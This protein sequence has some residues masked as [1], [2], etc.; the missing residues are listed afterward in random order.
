VREHP[1]SSGNEL[2]GLY[3][4]LT[5]GGTI[6]VLVDSQSRLLKDVSSELRSSRWARLSVALGLA[7]HEPLRS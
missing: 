6:E 1:W 2:T 5:D 3:A 4:R 7:R